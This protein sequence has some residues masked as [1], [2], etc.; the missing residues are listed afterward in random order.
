MPIWLAK[1]RDKPFARQA[2]FHVLGSDNQSEL[3]CDY[4]GLNV[5]LN[6][7]RGV[8]NSAEVTGETLETCTPAQIALVLK[9]CTPAQIALALNSKRLTGIERTLLIEDLKQGFF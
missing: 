3:H 7:V 9:S 1:T 2:R 8:L 6:M 4:R 5:G